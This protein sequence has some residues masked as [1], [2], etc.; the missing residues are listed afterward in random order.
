MVG[1]KT[2]KTKLTNKAL[3]SIHNPTNI[4]QAITVKTLNRRLF[5]FMIITQLLMQSNIYL[6]ENNKY[7][8]KTDIFANIFC[9]GL[10]LNSLN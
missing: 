8:L 7:I 3:A 4:I 2:L 5:G 1:L 9:E 6:L 10:I